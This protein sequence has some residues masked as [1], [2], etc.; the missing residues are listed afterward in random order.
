[1]KGPFPAD[2][3]H[4]K[5]AKFSFK[6]EN[7]RARARVFDLV[8]TDETKHEDF[9]IVWDC[10][11]IVIGG[12]KIPW[13][14]EKP[15]R[16]ISQGL[17]IGFYSMSRQLR[18]E[19]RITNTVSMMESLY[20]HRHLVK[21]SRR[22]A[23]GFRNGAVKYSE[24][25]IQLES[26]H[27]MDFTQPRQYGPGLI[28]VDGVLIDAFIRLRLPRSTGTMSYFV[29]PEWYSEDGTWSNPSTMEYMIN[30]AELNGHDCMYD[31][32]NG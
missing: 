25:R 11:K 30:E 32:I 8:Y 2:C 20:P 26:Y 29:K 9:R 19:S 15:N 1:M 18:S 10:G 3:Q 4:G 12:Q 21:L 14:D 28:I 5:V 23:N 17:S 27:T 13:V 24:H 31:Y 6:A 16:L 7:G 22:S